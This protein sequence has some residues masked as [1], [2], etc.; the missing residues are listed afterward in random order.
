MKLCVDNFHARETKFLHGIDRD[1]SSCIT[2]LDGGVGVE[3]DLDPVPMTGK[4]LVNG[5]VDD[6]PE[7]MHEATRVR[8]ADVHPR[9]LAYGLK[10]FE[11]RK[12]ARG[13]RRLGGC[14]HRAMLGGPSDIA[15]L[16]R[17]SPQI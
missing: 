3:D 11:H 7:A 16:A 2:H 1:S 14:G 15:G 4:C 17:L 8:G 13:V 9:A 12:M 10:A 5:V 6:F